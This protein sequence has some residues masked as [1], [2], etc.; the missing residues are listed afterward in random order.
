MKRFLIAVPAI[1]LI[2]AAQAAAQG[3]FGRGGQQ[4]AGVRASSLDMT[5]V[6]TIAGKVGA[7]DIS[8]GAQYPTFTVGAVTIKAAPV[9]F[10]LDNDF[11]LKAGDA[12]SVSAAPSTVANDSY[13]YAIQ[14]TNTATGAKIVLRDNNGL[15]LWSGPGAGRGNPDAIRDGTCAGCVDAATIATIAGTV[16]KVVMGYGIQMPS[17][18]VKGADG[19]LITMK[20][21]PERTLLQADFELKAGDRVTARYAYATCSEEY[22]ALQLTNASGV[23]VT[24]RN[25]DGTPA[26]N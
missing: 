8:L 10:L 14:I 7:I 11:E 2:F 3:P 6:Q 20:I 23:V 15:P 26:W 5:K 4:G 17:L 1:A 19:K 12:V 24:L 25:D 13:L 16:E 18:V 21:G 22:V 9:W